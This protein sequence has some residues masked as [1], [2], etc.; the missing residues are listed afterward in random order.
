[1]SQNRAVVI[2]AGAS[3]M[4]AA[5]RAGECGYH[6]TLLEKGQKPGRK[7]LATGNGRC[8]L[9]N[10][11]APVYFGEADFA[12][13]VLQQCGA[14][15]VLNTFDRW[16]LQTIQEE[17]GRVYPACGQAQAVLDVLLCRLNEIH[18]SIETD[19]EVIRI[20]KEQG[21]FRVM[22]ADYREFVAERCILATGGMAGGRLG[23]EYSAYQLAASLGHRMTDLSPALVPIMTDKGSVRSLAGLRVPAIVTLMD[24]KQPVSAAQGEVL[25]ADYGLS[26]ICVMQLASECD[27]LLDMGRSPRLKVDFSPLLNVCPRKYGRLDVSQMPDW[28]AAVDALLRRRAMLVPEE[29]VLVGLLPAALARRFADVPL[30]NLADRLCGYIIPVQG[31]RSM[32][33]AQVTHGGVFAQDVDPQTMQSK[34]CEGLYLT[35]EMLNVDGDCG[36]FNLL[37]AFATGLLAGENLN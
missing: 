9:C 35:G 27:A 23:C 10:T 29:R 25:F 16:G 12:L 30:K 18:A 33:Y 2:G 1:M 5:I 28:R 36:G 26:G 19:S 7:L 37:F 22:T 34:C 11:G 3:G 6:V 4:A 24:G 17:E 31:I 21:L 14:S 8:N 20:R 13:K 32:E 15:R